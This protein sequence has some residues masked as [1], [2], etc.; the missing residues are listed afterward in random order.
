MK[1]TARKILAILISALLI[2][3]F[4][5]GCSGEE[6][7]SGSSQTDPNPSSQSEPAEE[8]K[9]E[10]SSEPSPEPSE[11]SSEIPAL[12]PEQV[13]GFWEYNVG[14]D[15]L[16]VLINEDN[17]AAYYY[18]NGTVID[19]R[20]EIDGNKL[21]VFA[22]GGRQD[23]SY[24]DEKL[25]DSFEGHV[26]YKGTE[27]VPGI[28]DDFDPVGYWELSGADDSSGIKFYDDGSAV[29]QYADGTKIDG[30]WEIKNGTL[31]VYTAESRQDFTYEDGTLIDR[32]D[33]RVYQKSTLPDRDEPGVE[34]GSFDPVGLW[35][36]NV[37][38]D[39]LA[40]RINS[41]GTALYI[42]SDGTEIDARWSIENGKLSVF[43][44]GGRQNFTFEEDRITDTYSDHVFFKT[45]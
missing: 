37:G 36:Y 41:D 27:P 43:A 33:G 44:F 12:S 7:S 16:G 14:D 29:Y 22:A 26:Y 8:S 31:S 2:V 19:A 38:G 10:P 15:Y 28:P 9:P 40:I 25:T 23:F 5:A 34:P 17:S 42:Y 6:S 4:A 20:W 32:A 39:Y 24:D 18:S 13:I 21:S 35:E 3:C 30:G 45:S 1:T 11:E